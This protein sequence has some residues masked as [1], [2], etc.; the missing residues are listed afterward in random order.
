MVEC[1]YEKRAMSFVSSEPGKGAIVILGS[2]EANDIDR[3]KT[4]ILI[5]AFRFTL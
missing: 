3:R 4:V 1:A 5:C 2:E